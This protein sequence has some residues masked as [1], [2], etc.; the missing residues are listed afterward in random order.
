MIP[1]VILV[2]LGATPEFMLSV[3]QQIFWI[4]LWRADLQG[5]WISLHCRNHDKIQEKQT[6]FEEILHLST[7]QSG[8][9]EI[10]QRLQKLPAGPVFWKK[11]KTVFSSYPNSTRSFNARPPTLI[12]WLPL[13]EPWYWSRSWPNIAHACRW[14][15]KQENQSLYSWVPG[16]QVKLTICD[17]K[18]ISGCP[19]A[20]QTKLWILSDIAAAN[21]TL[22]FL[23]RSQSCSL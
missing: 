6:T 10:L 16:D 23:Q 13:F 4:H 12:S 5:T 1:T 18:N 22:S 2:T 14:K 8:L 3:M 21:R 7:Q 19:T 15:Q 11:Q 17:E 9:P 20:S